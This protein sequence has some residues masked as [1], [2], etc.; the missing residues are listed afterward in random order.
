MISTCPRCDRPVSVPAGVD[1]SAAVR[2]PL[3]DAEYALAEA[4]T[5]PPP[6]LIPVGLSAAPASTA[7]AEDMAAETTH[8]PEALPH[9][10]DVENEAAAVAEAFPAKPVAPRKRRKPKSALQTLIEV[11]AGG[12]AG[13]L[14]AYYGLA[15]YYGPEFGAK[16][17]PILPLPGIERITAAQ[18]ASD[19]AKSKLPQ[20][21]PAKSKQKSSRHEESAASSSCTPE[22]NVIQ[23]G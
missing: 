9:D 13:C 5:P 14:V 16:G 7:A 2:C 22:Q 8:L 15:F 18:P 6:E 1:S 10:S 11:V 3:C 23:L 17:L 20:K 19:D 21:K 4:L 12:L